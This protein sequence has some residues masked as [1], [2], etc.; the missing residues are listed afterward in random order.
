MTAKSQETGSADY[1]KWIIPA[2]I[3]F[4]ILL[5][6]LYV[7]GT[8]NDLVSSQVAIDTAWGQVQS[9]YQRRVDLIPNLVATVQGAANFEKSTLLAVTEARTQWLNAKTSQ[10]QVVA[11]NQ[12]EGTIAKLLF[13]VESYPQLKSSQNFLALQDE[14]AGTENRINVERQ[15]YNQAVGNY[16]AK[17]RY[18]PGSIMA[19]LFHFEKREFFQAQK[20][21]ENVPKVSFQ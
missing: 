5:F 12:L 15:R 20:G 9:V 19:S 3:V 7:M 6:A 16:N 10:E 4:A 1:R 11:A 17:I 18:F 8:Y 2:A 21:A 13:T 14:L